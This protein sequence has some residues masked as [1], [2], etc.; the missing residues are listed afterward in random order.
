MTAPPCRVAE[1]GQVE[2]DRAE[3]LQVKLVRAR[4]AGEVPDTLLLLEHPPVVTVGR[5]TRSLPGHLNA[6][7][8]KGLGVEMRSSSRGGQLTYHGPGQIVGY[9]VL[10]LRALEPDLHWYLRSLEQVVINTLAAFGYQAVRRDGLTGVWL[11]GRKVA[12]IGI[13]VRGW[14]SYHGFALNVTCPRSAW[15]HL[16]PCGLDA[17]QVV[18]LHELGPGCPSP[19]GLRRTIAEELC[20]LFGRTLQPCSPEELLSQAVF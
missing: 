1:L 7:A 16:R 2:Y 14:V 9:P 8:L 20:T 6:Q 5:A 12:S 10:D 15:A 11:G 3:E 4:R 17:D 18:S 19:A 13:A